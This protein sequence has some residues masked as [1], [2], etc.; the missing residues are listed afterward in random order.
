MELFDFSMCLFILF[1]TY[2]TTY[3]CENATE[4]KSLIH[5][6]SISQ[7]LYGDCVGN[8]YIQ[9]FIDSFLESLNFHHHPE[10]NASHFGACMSQCIQHGNCSALVYDVNDGCYASLQGA[11]S[12]PGSA[13]H[14][15][16]FFS[17]IYIDKDSLQA[18]IAYFNTA[19]SALSFSWCSEATQDVFV[20]D[21][22]GDGVDDLLC[23]QR[24]AGGM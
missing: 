8:N 23:H 12:S 20:G 22:N 2:P 13:H 15:A 10:N 7:E 5:I 21:F 1:N 24:R 18:H 3:A 11:E 6:S 17:N 4:I 19:Q 16:S 9:P 14:Q